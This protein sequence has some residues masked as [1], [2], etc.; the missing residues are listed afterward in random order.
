M[1]HSELKTGDL[2]FYLAPN[3]VSE[4]VAVYAGHRNGM[5]YV[6]HA[7]TSP[8]NAI[9]LTRLKPSD[10]CCAY[11]IFRP[12]N[13][14]LACVATGILLRWI[15]HQIPFAHPSKRDPLINYLDAI[16]GFLDSPNTAAIGPIQEQ[17]GKKTYVSSYAQYF[18]MIAALPWIPQE[19]GEIKGLFCS[20]SIIAAFNM[21]LLIMHETCFRNADGGYEWGPNPRFSLDV[22]TASLAN[23]L[24]FDAK[25]T[26]P[27]GMFKHCSEDVSNWS[28]LGELC[29]IDEPL[30]PEISELNKTDWL[31]FKTALRQ[32]VPE[33]IR[34]LMCSPAPKR[35]DDDLTQLLITTHSDDE[36]VPRSSS[37]LR[38]LGLMARSSSDELDCKMISE[39]AATISPGAGV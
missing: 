26:L 13:S 27:A 14:H 3:G 21:A 6:A 18:N 15:E 35:V 8:Y 11:M 12:N 36:L 19:D 25:T 37:P 23:P 4:H 38:F 28:S 31:E 9:M 17:H 16:G 20:E 30:S 24:P 32:K 10:L 29:I 7:T 1:I 34:S 39:S 22:F 5:P 33:E 2:V